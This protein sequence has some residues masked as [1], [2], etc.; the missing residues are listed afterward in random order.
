MLFY[1]FILDTYQISSIPRGASK[2]GK[3]SLST[4]RIL[5][6]HR[7]YDIF[8]ASLLVTDAEYWPTSHVFRKECLN[9]LLA[10]ATIFLVSFRVQAG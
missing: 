1:P 9:L 5:P 7:I 8:N 10:A 2:Q 4:H 6:C 3:R